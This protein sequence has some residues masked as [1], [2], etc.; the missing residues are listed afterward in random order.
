MRILLIGEYSNVHATL[1]EAFRRAGH[2]VLLLSDGDDWKNYRRDISIKRCRKGKPGTLHLLIQWGLQLPKLRGYDIVHFVNPKFTDMNPYI[3]KL[4]FRWLAR[5][6][7]HVSLGLYGDDYVVLSQLEKGIL[8]YSELQAFGKRINVEAQKQR[9]RSW[10]HDCKNICQEV[11]ARAETLVACLYEYHYLYSSLK[12]ESINSRLHYI[13]L[14]I[15]SPS[16]SP[17]PISGKVKILFGIQTQRITTKGYDMMLP[18]FQRLAASHPEE[19]ELTIVEDVPFHEYRLLLD[20]CDVLVDQ[21]YSYTPAMNA[22]EAMSRGIIVVSGGEE[23]YYRFIGE[24]NLRPIIN[25]RPTEDEKNYRIIE[26]TLLDRHR[27]HTM[28]QAS[29]DFIAKYHDADNIANEYLNLWK[30]LL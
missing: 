24:K 26:E 23:D 27:L 3:D 16:Q 25:L 7:K 11:T 22:L 29:I 14:P 18:L 28:K 13:G 4:I 10:T 6:N 20:S 2:E 17:K 19:I 9:I 12:D 8:E 30:S 5:H 1:A 15:K 21:Y